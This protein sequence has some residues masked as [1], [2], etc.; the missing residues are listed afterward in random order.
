MSFDFSGGGFG[1]GPVLIFIA[2]A[3][4]VIVA[5]VFG[6]M[7]ARKRREALAA[8]A[9][10]F[11]MTFAEGKDR[12]YEYTFPDF[13][14]LKAGE[15]DRYAQNVVSGT[16]RNRPLRAFDYHYITTSTDN[17]GHRTTHHHRFSAVIV[18]CEIP[19]KPLQ[20]RPEG[21]FDKIGAA[22][23]FEDIN[24]ESAEF[25]RRFKVTAPDRKWAYDVLHARAIEFLLAQPPFSMQFG[26]GNQVMFW[27]GG[28]WTPGQFEAA[29]NSVAGL[30]DLLPRYLKEQQCGRPPPLV[31]EQRS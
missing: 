13:R 15:G 17:K 7:Q 28:T 8:W 11:G 20:L 18:G 29:A 9:A 12:S 4:L 5:A 21:F 30:L 26:C 27:T 14:H 10:G 19:L 1:G 31:T 24:F 22:F 16:F 3:T 23:G 6:A 2:I 25:S